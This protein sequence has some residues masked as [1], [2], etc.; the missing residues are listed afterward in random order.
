MSRVCYCE[1]HPHQRM[2]LL[3]NH[4]WCDICNPPKGEIKEKKY[5]WWNEIWSV[6]VPDY[7]SAPNYIVVNND[8]DRHEIADFIFETQINQLLLT[9]K[10]KKTPWILGAG[11]DIVT[12]T[13]KCLEELQK[14]SVQTWSGLQSFIKVP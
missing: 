7:I 13:N 8:P 6:M 1:K 3:F 9:V 10:I 12:V 4:Y 14:S 11:S 2:V 5:S